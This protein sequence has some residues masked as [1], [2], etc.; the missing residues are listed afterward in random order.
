M[1][2]HAS[3][4]A[5]A[6]VEDAITA[7]LHSPL[8]TSAEHAFDPAGLARS[9][10]GASR[11]AAGKGRRILLAAGARPVTGDP[12]LCATALTRM[13][14]WATESFSGLPSVTIRMG[15]TNGAMLRI[16]VG[17][18]AA[19]APQMRL[20]EFR[21]VPV[22]AIRSAV[23]AMGAKLVL[24]EHQADGA[25][26]ASFSLPLAQPT[27]ATEK[28]TAA[29]LRILVV[30]DAPAITRLVARMV[31]R[32]GH[33][34]EECH[35]GGE[36]VSRAAA[37][38][39]DVVL[40]DVSMPDMG[41]LEAAAKIRAGGRSAQARLII[42]SANLLPEERPRARLLGV[43]RILMKPVTQAELKRT[44]AQVP[45]ES[46]E[47]HAVRQEALALLTEA[48]GQEGLK[49]LLRE[50][51]HELELVASRAADEGKVEELARLVHRCA[52][53]AAILG[54]TDLHAACCTYELALRSNTDGTPAELARVRALFL[55]A[56]D[57]A[58]ALLPELALTVT[59][60]A[61]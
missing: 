12:Q 60:S 1:A 40:L 6:R 20:P 56:R 28:P 54:L 36:A 37:V 31:E 18:K 35:S 2:R 17:A 57:H 38:G 24:H 43:E 55:N 8:S 39:F 41:G 53:S 58:M 34:A 22:E 52:G 46:L 49:S 21:P 44:L 33:T 3:I 32:L 10:L 61:R 45:D 42:L 14:E 11:A 48:L 59:G 19:P 23:E 26:S 25:I 9:I 4:N 15:P 51:R 7:A 13:V 47:G 27:P 50:L 16:T 30:D 29:S 5:I